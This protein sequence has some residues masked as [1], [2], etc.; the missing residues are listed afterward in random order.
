MIGKKVNKI[1]KKKY[2]KTNLVKKWQKFYE[3]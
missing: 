2:N 1:F 3:L